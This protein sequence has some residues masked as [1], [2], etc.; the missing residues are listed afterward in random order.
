MH[1]QVRSGGYLGHYGLVTGRPGRIEASAREDSTLLLIPLVRLRSFLLPATQPRTLPRGQVL[2]REGDPADYLYFILEGLMLEES[3][4]RRGGKT[5]AGSIPRN[6]VNPQRLVGRGEYLGRYALQTAQPFHATATAEVDTIYLAIPLRELQPL[7]F[8]HSNWRDWFFQADVAIRLRAVP[9]FKDLDDWS[10]YLL[11]DH[12]R[13]QEY[14]KGAYIFR[15]GQQAETFFVVDQGRVSEDPAPMGGTWYLSAGNFFGEESLQTGQQ[16]QSTAIAEDETRLFAIPG[17]E[18]GE[19]LTPYLGNLP[20]NLPRTDLVSRLK[21]VPLFSKRPD[22]D[23]RLLAGYA[24][25]VLHRPGDIVSRQGEPATSLMILDEGEAVVLRKTGKE[26][27]RPVRYLKVQK[28]RPGPSARPGPAEGEYFGAQALLSDEM[29]G[30]AVEVTQASTWIVVDRSDFEKFMAEARL[31]KEDLG[32]GSRPDVKTRAPTPSEADHLPLPFHT[33]RHWIVPVVNVLPF[34]LLIG[35]AG[36]W[37]LTSLR[38]GSSGGGGGLLLALQI[39]ILVASLLGA[40][41]FYLDWWN[42]S[43]QVTSQAVIHTEKKVLLSEERYE[44]PLRQIQN[45]N[46]SVSPTG[47]MLGYGDLSIDTAAAKGQVRFTRIPSPA[48]VQGLIQRAASEAKSGRQI[49]FRES[50]RQQLE[51]QL[52]PERIKPSAPSSVF[53]QPEPPSP[54]PARFARF[55]SLRGWFPRFEIR[56]GSTITWRK[57][58]FNLVQRTGLAGL[59]SLFAFYLLFAYLL[60]V[61]T[62]VFGASSPVLL[63]PL[64]WFGTGGWLLFVVLILSIVTALWFVYQYID[65]RNDIY[66][67]SDNEVTDVERDLAAFPLGFFFY[68]ESRRQASLAN[69]QYVDFKIPNPIAMLFNYGNVIVQTAGAEGTLDFL[70]VSNPRHVHAVI[71]RRLNEFQ[72]RQRQREFQERW[73]DMP[74]WFETFRDIARQSEENQD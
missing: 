37:L 3:G 40:G 58:W 54:R 35:L 8:I 36:I 72:E 31:T 12:V 17:S 46:I 18:I 5:T 25:L 56:E 59:A 67:V 42:D 49:A 65:W 66:I 63:P 52:N 43:Y 41:W 70:F 55:R 7:L 51:D 28:D 50:I 23:L 34:A 68:T 74:Q 11:A 14:E 64:S 62:R 10:I 39:L 33:R 6:D 15:L 71:L 48:Y 24:S 22:R 27:P 45:V 53:I 32:E 38:P 20:D 47:Q 13:V 61:V 30:A 26:R 16:R 29:R 4:N 57:H 73:G 44:A 21:S 1:R 19:R 2:F 69:V 60:A 9:L